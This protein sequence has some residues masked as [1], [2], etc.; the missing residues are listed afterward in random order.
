MTPP[1]TTFAEGQRRIFGALMALS[2]VFYGF[3]A[4]AL[5]YVLVFGPWTAGTEALRLKILAGG[6]AGFILGSISVTIALAV[7]GPVGRFKVS[8][9]KDGA[10]VEADSSAATVTTTTTETK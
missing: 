6:M 7:G 3:C 2:G 1:P 5:V 4:A 9:N 10:S 8:A